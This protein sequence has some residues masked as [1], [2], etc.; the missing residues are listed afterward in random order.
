MKSKK[1]LFEFLA[2]WTDDRSFATLGLKHDR[3]GDET[4]GRK[5]VIYLR[6][7]DQRSRD[8]LEAAMRLAGFKVS[9]TYWRDSLRMSAVQ[10]SYFKGWHYDE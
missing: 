1:K 4:Y 5:S 3:V 7:A 6:S 9:R 10:V 8:E 2:D